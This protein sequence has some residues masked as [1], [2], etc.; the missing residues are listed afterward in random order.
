[1]SKDKVVIE[2]KELTHNLLGK[3]SKISFKERSS[4]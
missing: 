1:M 3:L 2:V 4:S